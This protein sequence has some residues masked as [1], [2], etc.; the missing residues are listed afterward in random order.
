VD[1]VYTDAYESATRFMRTRYY[2]CYAALALVNVGNMAS[3]TII[4]FLLPYDLFREGLSIGLGSAPGIVAS[5]YYVG[6]LVGGLCG[7][8]LSDVFG[9]RSVLLLSSTLTATFGAFTAC[10]TGRFV[11]T[12]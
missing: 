7:G 3:S 6:A 11:F 2:C 4:A 12:E 10:A 1:D 9:R 8:T 5:S